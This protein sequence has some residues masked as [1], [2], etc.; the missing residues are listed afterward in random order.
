MIAAAPPAKPGREAACPVHRRS[1]RAVL[2][3]PPRAGHGVSLEPTGPVPGAARLGWVAGP[4]LAVAVTVFAAAQYA[5]GHPLAPEA[6]LAITPLLASLTL[7]PLRTALL[8]GW[9]VLL[10]L[11][12]A[13]RAG[14]AGP[15]GRLASSLAVLALLAG[16][17]VAN[18]VLRSAAQRRLGQ[19]RAVARVAQS[20][21]LREVPRSVAAARLAS[22]YL[23]ASAEAQVGGDLVEVIADGAN[24][25]WLVG[26]TRGK[27]LPAV[28]LA[29]VAATSFRD[30]CAR[31]GLSLI[32]VARAVEE[33]VMRAADEEDFVTAV[34]AELD[35][36]GWIELVICGHPPPLRLST[37]GELAPLAPAAFTAPLACT[38]TCI[39]P[40]SRCAPATGCCSSPTGCWRPATGRAGSSGWTSRSRR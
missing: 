29:S 21:L 11:G 25:R 12:L 31:P 34:F 20:A 24:P 28:R 18:S 30:A 7:G 26:D 39:C 16:F 33:S 37:D 4:L 19:A 17:G 10:G 5:I 32:E 40:R 27:G 22:R 1:W 15:A 35:P 3:W 14:P 13:L 23:S 36:A 6:W 9:T 2:A 38:R 8:A